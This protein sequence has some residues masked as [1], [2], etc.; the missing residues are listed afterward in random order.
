VEP[1]R[2][3]SPGERLII[4]TAALLITVVFAP[5]VFAGAPLA[6]DFNNCLTPIHRG[7]GHFLASS[8]DRLEMVR[9]ARFP[10]ILLTTGACRQLHFG[11]AIAVPAALTVAIAY[12]LAGLLRDVGVGSPWP[13]V[14]GALWLLQPLGTES[15][16]WPAA[17]HVCLGLLLALMAL[18]LHRRGR[19]ASGVAATLGACFSI[20]QAILAL[21]AAVW[22]T[23]SRER[24]RRATILTAATILLVVISFALW[25]GSDPRLQSSIGDRLVAAWSDPGFLILFPAVG[26]G[27]HSIPLAIGWAWPASVL[28][29]LSA[30]L[31]GWYLGARMITPSAS[32]RPVASLRAVLGSGAMLIALINIPVIFAVE[33]QGSPRIFTPTWLVLAGVLPAALAGRA[34]S[35]NRV[36]WAAGGLF[37]AGAL[38]SLALSVSVRVRSADFVQYAAHRIAGDVRDGGDVGLCRV[39]RTVTEPAPRGAFA[40][41]EFVYDWAAQDALRYYTDVRASFRLA[42]EL[43]ER[44]CP[45]SSEVD[46]R[47]R[48]DR[49]VDDWSRA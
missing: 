45:P 29:L 6:D 15:A 46:E 18:R 39:R 25:H 49:L 30:G 40:I 12:V 19:H 13:Q 35:T 47:L 26:M 37:A 34:W 16:L 28:A 48:F 4:P 27:A 21:P 31:V 9:L 24:R 38:L 7:L 11:L 10:E 42:G 2:S 36:V 41:H 14:A 43:W 22:V 23:C 3:R 33:H 17:L 8:W 5:V 1:R 44:P 20:E 32:M